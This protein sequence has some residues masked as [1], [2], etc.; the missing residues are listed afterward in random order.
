M[1]FI[2]RAIFYTLLP[3]SKKA[4]L[5]VLAVALV[6]MIGYTAVASST[7]H[8]W[9]GTLPSCN[10]QLNSERQIQIATDFPQVDLSNSTAICYDDEY[11]QIY[12]TATI[13]NGIFA[14]T[15]PYYEIMCWYGGDGNSPCTLTGGGQLTDYWTDDTLTGISWHGSGGVYPN[16]ASVIG[17][18]SGGDSGDNKLLPDETVGEITTGFMALITANILP[19]LGILGIVVGITYIRK[20]FNGAGML[21]NAGYDGFDKVT[22][23]KKAFRPGNSGRGNFR[24]YQ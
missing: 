21:G 11:I 5:I 22:T 9:S 6:G 24:D 10:N 20:L 14:L 2:L 4:R 17:G 3:R 7:T 13:E 16:Y 23:A 19:I 12:D 1:G 8:A 18:G 15:Q